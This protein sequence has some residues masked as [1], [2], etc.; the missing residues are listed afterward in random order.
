MMTDVV[1][2]NMTHNNDVQEKINDSLHYLEEQTQFIQRVMQA[3]QEDQLNDVMHILKD[4]AQFVTHDFVQSFAGKAIADYLVES[5]A[6]QLMTNYPFLHQL[7]EEDN[8]QKRTFY[9]GEWY[10]ADT[11]HILFLSINLQNNRYGLNVKI[12]DEVLEEWNNMDDVKGSA[13]DDLMKKEEALVSAQEVYE[14][15]K[16]ESLA[17]HSQKLDDL[18][19]K[20]HALS[21]KVLKKQSDIQEVDQAIKKETQ[22]LRSIEEQPEIFFNDEYQVIVQTKESIEALKARVENMNL[23]EALVKREKNE[24]TASGLSILEFTEQIESLQNQWE[25]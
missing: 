22:I 20:Y 17:V 15:K 19:K 16:K 18:R 10:K 3:I 25:N 6:N 1:N 13:H 21:S 11:R 12:A 4:N 5:A 23:I 8:H 9:I 7:S 24:I 2:H 14:T